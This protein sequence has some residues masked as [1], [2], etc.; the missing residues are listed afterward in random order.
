VWWWLT[1]LHRPPLPL[2]AMARAADAPR[3]ALPVTVEA[4]CVLPQ[5]EAGG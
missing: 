3:A 5:G 1:S 2:D 4:Y